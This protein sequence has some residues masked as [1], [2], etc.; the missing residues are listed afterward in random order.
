MVRSKFGSRVCHFPLPKICFFKKHPVGVESAMVAT[1]RKELLQSLT[2]FKKNKKDKWV[3]D[4]P[5][6]MIITGSQVNKR[7][8]FRIF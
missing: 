7:F 4:T 5:G 2:N 6:Q 3:K 8:A 1:L